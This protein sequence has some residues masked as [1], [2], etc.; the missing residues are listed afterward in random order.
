M[1]NENFW[2]RCLKRFY[3]LRALDEYRKNELHRIN[4]QALM[5]LWFVYIF[6]NLIPVVLV[7]NKIAQII[8]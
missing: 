6:L 4:S 1:K 8:G 5:A 2:N 7:H 3:G